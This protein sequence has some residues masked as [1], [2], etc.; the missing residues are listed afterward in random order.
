[1]HLST[2]SKKCEQNMVAA[3]NNNANVNHVVKE[4]GQYPESLGK[5]A[6]QNIRQIIN[7]IL[8]FV[9]SWKT[10]FLGFAILYGNI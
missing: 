5:S 2:R 1:M 9:F 4:E 6:K 7:E 3:L 10:D 8:N